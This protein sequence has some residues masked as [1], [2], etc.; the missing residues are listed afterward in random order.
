[1][2]ISKI[3]AKG[4]TTIPAKIRNKLEL[5]IGD[6]VVYEIKDEGVLVRK[7]AETNDSYLSAISSTLEEWN[8]D[9]DN[10]A[11]CDL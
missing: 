8:S 9:E 1:M 7:V 11:W 6:T 5:G 2:E 10:E 3:S 4:Q